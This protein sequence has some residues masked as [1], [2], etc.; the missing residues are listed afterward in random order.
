MNIRDVAKRAGV[1][2]A[3]V[4]R[5]LNHPDQ[6]TDKTRNRILDV[7]KEMSYTPNWFARG[8]NLN[9]TGLIALMIPNIVNPIYTEIAK[10]VE[11]VAH[12]K[13]YSTF[14]CNTEDSEKKESDYIEMLIHRKVDGLIFIGGHLS[15]AMM[16]RIEKDQ[17]PSVMIGSVQGD[18]KFSQVYTDFF[19]GARK[20]TSHLIENGIKRIAHITGNL[21]F[22][23]NQEKL[24]GYRTAM[25]NAGFE[26]EDSWVLSGE[27][28]IEGG[29]LAAKQ[30]VRSQNPPDAI[31]IANDWMAFGAMDAIKSEGLSIPKNIAIVGF[32]NNRMSAL[33]DPKLTTVN[34]PANKMG[35]TAC[36]LLFDE[37]ESASEEKNSIYIPVTLKIRQSCGLSS[38]IKT[39]FGE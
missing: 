9:R 22:I 11:E 4:S 39:I 31:F 20:A 10:G 16:V 29:Y 25:E 14:L 34:L 17:L 38:G 6:V 7:M 19:D 30:L 2:V 13:G 35:L 12:S 32:D 23:E 8:L 5:V 15:E 18:W 27:D 28:T 33:V 3:T 1:S 37:I 36:R 24:K 21:R 26:I